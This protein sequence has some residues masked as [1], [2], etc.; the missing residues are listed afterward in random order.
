MNPGAP[1][2]ATDAQ[3]GLFSPIPRGQISNFN[4]ADWTIEI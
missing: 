3:F 2:G 4:L 1:P